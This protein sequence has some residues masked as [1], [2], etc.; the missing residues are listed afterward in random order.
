MRQQYKLVFSDIDGTLLDN[1]HSI[2]TGT[3]KKILELEQKGIFFIL[4]SARMPD[5]I[6]PVKNM[7]NNHAPVVSYSGA[8]IQDQYG[9][10]IRSAGIDSKA[11]YEVKK[12][13]SGLLPDI[14][15][16]IY[17][18]NRWIVEDASDERIKRESE[19]I[20]VKP[21]EGKLKDKLTE[22]EIV[23]KLLFMG[24]PES[25]SILEVELKKHFPALSVRKSSAF[26][27]E[28]RRADVTKADA[29]KI[30]CD[31]YRVAEED[32]LAFGDQFDDLEMLFAAGVG[33]AMG[34]APE[35]I[36]KQADYVTLSNDQ[37]GL[38]AALNK[39]TI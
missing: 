14:C 10:T 31:L 26:Y 37:E 29:V 38:L 39:Y 6:L 25:I 3:R 35:E 19:I 4:V 27:L 15:C 9:K 22:D 5:G 7:L 20:H 32:T 18:A 33:I 36:K 12:F 23:H 11:A 28:V 24:E 16:N 34:N 2:T 13:V 17:S 8:L 1:N 30:I 21:E